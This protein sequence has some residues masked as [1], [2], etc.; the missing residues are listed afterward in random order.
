MTGI[1]TF[2][3]TLINGLEPCHCEIDCILPD[4]EGQYLAGAAMNITVKL[5]AFKEISPLY[6]ALLH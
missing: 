3:L 5:L 2:D 4:K 6:E 1:L